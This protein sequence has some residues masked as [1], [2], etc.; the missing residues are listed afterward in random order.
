MSSEKIWSFDTTSCDGSQ[1][2][3]IDF[4]RADKMATAHALD[5]IG[6]DHVD[7]RWPVANPAASV[8]LSN[9]VSRIAPYGA[10]LNCPPIFLMPLSPH[11]VMA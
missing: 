10:L 7:V 9:F 3:I 2:R 1:A 5:D 8:F 4:S 6:I 11:L